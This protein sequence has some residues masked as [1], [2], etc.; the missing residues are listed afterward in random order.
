MPS[1]KGGRPRS[2]PVPGQGCGLRALGE[3]GAR[4]RRVGT[5]LGGPR[6]PARATASGL[7]RAVTAAA[8]CARL[9]CCAASRRSSRPL[10]RL[11]G[12]PHAGC[13]V[14]HRGPLSRGSGSGRPA[15]VQ[16]GGRPDGS[17]L[18]WCA[19]GAGGRTGV[20]SAWPPRSG[21]AGEGLTRRGGS[22]LAEAFWPRPARPSAVRAVIA[23]RLPPSAPRCGRPAD[24]RAAGSAPRDAALP[25]QD[26]RTL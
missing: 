24:R 26:S 5:R 10:R 17:F 21:W 7:G 8:A 12:G 16:D 9:G 13:S 25:L 11:F 4:R 1:R 2:A 15:S 14:V 19:R 23:Y 20:W 3:A 18:G 22:R 6:Y